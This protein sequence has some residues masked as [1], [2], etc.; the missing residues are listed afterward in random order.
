MK[1]FLQHRAWKIGIALL[2]LLVTQMSGEGTQK[3]SADIGPPPAPTGAGF[4]PAGETTN[5]RMMWE[6]VLLDIAG[7]SS[8]RTGHANVTAEFVMRNLGD[9]E[10]QMRVRFPLTYALGDRAHTGDP[11]EIPVI[12]LCYDHPDYPPLTEFQVW[13][14]DESVEHIT[15]YEA[16]IYHDYESDEWIDVMVPCWE[17]FDVTFPPGQDVYI[18]VSYV[19]PAT[20]HS[21]ESV[22]AYVLETGAGWRDTIGKATI[23]ARLPYEVDAQNMRWCSPEDCIVSGTDITWTYED[24]EPDFNISTGITRPEIWLAILTERENVQ[25][26]PQDGE[27]W[28][29]LGK[30]YKEALVV[31]SEGINYHI[32]LN[33]EWFNLSYEAYTHAVTLLPDDADWHY[34]FADLLCS[35]ALFGWGTYMPGDSIEICYACAEQ[36]KFTLDINP[37][38]EGAKYLLEIIDALDHQND[39]IRLRDSTPDFLVLTPSPT[40]SLTPM[41][42]PTSTQWQPN[43]P[44]VVPTKSNTPI[45]SSTPEPQSTPARPSA[46]TGTNAPVETSAPD[47]SNAPVFIGASVLLVALVLVVTVI[48]GRR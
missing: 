27:A 28:G 43:T 42:S 41:P 47:S 48:K 37:E 4:Y 7:Y 46:A 36:I 34:G 1:T 9:V 2:I 5:V 29:R 39:I 23:V 35:S 18:K 19:V 15:H 21:G 32:S 17:N 12:Y 25:N 40:P 6:Y 16:S 20:D 38:H 30:A 10:E 24:F 44:T 22:F 8:Y 13:V 26:N 3:A 14:N 31:T 45:A 11:D 33:Q